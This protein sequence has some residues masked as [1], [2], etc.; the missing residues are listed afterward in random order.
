MAFGFAVRRFLNRGLRAFGGRAKKAPGSK[1]G[2]LLVRLW[3]LL[4]ELGWGG[5]AHLF[6]NEVGNIIFLVGIK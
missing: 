4:V 2:G 1:Y 6:E 5:Y 3:R